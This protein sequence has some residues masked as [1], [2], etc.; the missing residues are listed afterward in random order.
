MGNAST[1][2]QE[3]AQQIIQTTGFDFIAELIQVALR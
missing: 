1:D 3:L 2:K